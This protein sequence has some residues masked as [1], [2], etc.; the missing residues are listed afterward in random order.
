MAL[1]NLN[2]KL[3]QE[4]GV[5]LGVDLTATQVERMLALQQSLVDVEE[6]PCFAYCQEY[7]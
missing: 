1:Q 3:A 6:S 5:Y 7:F 4:W 2:E